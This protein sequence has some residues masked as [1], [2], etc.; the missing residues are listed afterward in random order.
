MAAPYAGYN[1]RVR[2]TDC[3]VGA[4]CAGIVNAELRQVVITVDYRPLTGVGVA[5]AT[6]RKGAVVTLYVSRR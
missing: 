6:Q 1:R 3:G 5:A 4:G 2:I